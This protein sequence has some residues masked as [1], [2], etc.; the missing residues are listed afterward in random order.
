[1]KVFNLKCF[2]RNGFTLIELVVTIIIISIMA[3]TIM[4]KFLSLKGFEDNTYQNELITKLRAIQLRTMQQ[5][6][7]V[8]CQKVKITATSIGLLATTPTTNTCALSYAGDSTSVTIDPSHSVTF[9]ASE[10]LEHFYF[11]S[12]GR[13]QGCIAI[14]PCEITFSVTGESAL[15]IL[16][17]EQGYIYAI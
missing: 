17:N 11:S 6:N 3:V 7:N 12:L 14:S 8:V 1:M 16:I 5:T 2:M 13:P 10:N 9:T 15:K 4:P